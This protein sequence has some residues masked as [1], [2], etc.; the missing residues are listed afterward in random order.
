M[1]LLN[2]KAFFWCANNNTIDSNSNPHRTEMKEMKLYASHLSVNSSLC[3]MIVCV[4]YP[5]NKTVHV[6]KEK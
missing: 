6:C 2:R 3:Q 4:V 5:S 1:S